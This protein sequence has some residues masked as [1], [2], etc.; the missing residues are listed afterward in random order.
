MSHNSSGLSSC[1][2][3]ALYSFFPLPVEHHVVETLCQFHCVLLVVFTRKLLEVHVLYKDEAV[4]FS[5][6]GGHIMGGDQCY[7]YLRGP[8]TE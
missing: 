5:V 7:T 3:E 4:H 2:Y 6:G 8:T 1:S